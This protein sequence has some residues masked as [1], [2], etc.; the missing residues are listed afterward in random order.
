MPSF[1]TRTRSGSHVLVHCLV[2][3]V[4]FDV[5]QI[6]RETFSD[7]RPSPQ[8]Q[9]TWISYSSLNSTGFQ[10]LVFVRS[11][12]GDCFTGL[13]PEK[14]SRSGLAN[15]WEYAFWCLCWVPDAGSRR[16]RFWETVPGVAGTAWV[17]T[18]RGISPDMRTSCL[19]FFRIF[20]KA[21]RCYRHIFRECRPALPSLLP[22]ITKGEV[23]GRALFCA[24]PCHLT[25][26]LVFPCFLGSSG[27]AP[28]QGSPQGGTSDFLLV[29][30]VLIKIA[31]LASN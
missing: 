29:R 16:P 9:P 4:S 23:Q 31:N 21:L 24:L 15:V 5:G 20:F 11:T 6:T 2:S 13:L 17:N 25:C 30:R 19:Y 10:T 3:S 7:R 18:C 27:L 26:P 1:W 14:R 12:Q 22:F 8:R 28:P